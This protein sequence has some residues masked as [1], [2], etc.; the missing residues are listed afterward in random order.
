MA[1]SPKLV[2]TSQAAV[3][4]IA[5]DSTRFSFPSASRFSAKINE[6]DTFDDDGE[7]GEIDF[8]EVADLES[9]EEDDSDIDDVSALNWLHACTCPPTTHTHHPNSLPHIHPHF[10]DL[11]L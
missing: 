11:S 5:G 9:G 8:D 7:A 10:T 6:T 1:S 3:P 2:S 4:L